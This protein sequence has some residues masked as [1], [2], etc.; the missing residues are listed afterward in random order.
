MAD[1]ESPLVRDIF[2]SAALMHD[3]NDDS[4]SHLDFIDTDIQTDDEAIASP[5]DL[6][7]LS[8]KEEEIIE[9]TISADQLLLNS[10]FDLPEISPFQS[11]S[12]SIVID[13]S[14]HIVSSCS[15]P[16]DSNH[17]SSLSL[18]FSNPPE[19][20]YHVRYL[21]EITNSP[22]DGNIVNTKKKTKKNVSGRYLKGTHGRHVTIDFPIDL[23]DYCD[24]FI[25][26]TRLT[27]SYQNISFIHPYPLF[28]SH[29]KKKTHSDVII[30]DSSIYYKLNKGEICSHSKQFPNIILTRLKQCQLKHINTLR[31]FDK[32]DRTYPFIGNNAK[33]KI[34]IYQLK[35]SQLDFRLVIRCN[36]QTDEFVDLNISCRSNPLLE[37]EGTECKKLSISPSL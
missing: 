36:N 37:E 9:E 26:V 18:S 3:I 1:D 27:V 20:I 12:P 30:K 19:P 17:Y 32:S 35:K 6:F 21:S 34:A 29:P 22:V 4:L 31:S 14:Q 11:S 23:P 10:S 24:F 8:F 2:I 25:R 15:P 5:F 7:S 28:Y 16:I 13:W 33:S